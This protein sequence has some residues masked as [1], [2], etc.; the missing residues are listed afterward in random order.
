[1]K[2][3]T[4]ILVFLPLFSFSVIS[5]EAEIEY[6]I[7]SVRENYV[8]DKRICIYEVYPKK[9]ENSV[10]LKGRISDQKV[11]RNLLQAIDNKGITFTDSILLL[12]ENTIGQKHWGIVP[13]SAIYIRSKP[14]F[15][16]EITTQAT[17]G[18]PVKIL[19]KRGGWQLI[20]TPDQYIGWTNTTIQQIDKDELLRINRQ[21]KV[22]VTK[23]SSVV[24]KKPSEKSQ[25]IMEVLAGNIL[26]LEIK[27]I[28]G[29]FSHVSLP[30]G[31]KG[32]IVSN[33]VKT[34]KEWQKSI[35]LTGDNIVETGKQFLGLPYLW[36]GTSAR[37]MDCSGFT[38]TIYFLYG[39]ILPRD[40]SQ[41]FHCGDKIDISEDYANLQKGDLLFFGT[42]K[43]TNPEDFNVVHVAVYMG[44]K[45]FMHA[46]GQVRMDSLEPDSPDYDEYN[47]KRLVGARRI[48]GSSMK[49]VSNIFIN[50]WYN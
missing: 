23:Y 7:N 43:T 33:T 50:E 16:A 47:H 18:T 17:L 5:Q 4:L 24:Y 40:A 11:Y 42:K 45:K 48:I 15:T 39:L 9:S 10:V 13:L 1:M 27:K 46:S 20:Q 2:K 35:R 31:K 26:T 22:I 30:D 28:R 49:N 34:M 32:F 12:P 25:R 41:Q 19:D 36:G 21:T 38:K 29:E 6:I 37:G 3:I 44:N 8:P 14:D